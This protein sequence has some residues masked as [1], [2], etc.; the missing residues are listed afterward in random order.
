M[1]SLPVNPK[2]SPI[3]LAAN[4]VNSLVAVLLL[5]CTDH[6][7]ASQ[8]GKYSEAVLLGLISALGQNLKVPYSL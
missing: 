1:V 7:P 4:K 8:K 2:F 5:T 3:L 6:Q